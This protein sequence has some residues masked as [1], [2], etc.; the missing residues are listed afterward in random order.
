MEGSLI[1][2][3]CGLVFKRTLAFITV[4]YLTTA[5]LNLGGIYFLS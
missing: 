3:R 2:P 1:F 4:G 5:F